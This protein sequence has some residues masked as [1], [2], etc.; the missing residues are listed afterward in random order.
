[1]PGAA[2]DSG[3]LILRGRKR[4]RIAYLECIML[5]AVFL[6]GAAEDTVGTVP[7]PINFLFTKRFLT[8]CFCLRCPP[9]SLLPLLAQGQP[10][11]LSGGRIGS[12]FRLALSFIEPHPT[13]LAETYLGS[14][15][16]GRHERAPRTDRAFHG[17]Y[18]SRPIPPRGTRPLGAAE[19]RLPRFHRSRGV[20]CDSHERPV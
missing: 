4:L 1:M 16:R 20:V 3:L 18:F 2:A 14:V 15:T 19:S 10:P 17:D 7:L 13:H 5:R 8:F 12:L 11:N 6:S 9:V